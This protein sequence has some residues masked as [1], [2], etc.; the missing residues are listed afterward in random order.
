MG[1]IWNINEKASEVV[2]V[3]REGKH[4]DEALEIVKGYCTEQS[5]SNLDKKS[6]FSI[7]PNEDVDNGEVY[8]TTTGKTIR[9]LI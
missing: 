1:L 8:D 6:N 2:R 9:D 3:Y 5:N 4:Y 7:A